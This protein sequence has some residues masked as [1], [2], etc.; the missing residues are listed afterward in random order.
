MT[1]F[2]ANDYQLKHYEIGLIS[3]AGMHWTHSDITALTVRE[4]KYWM[5]VAE[6]RLGLEDA[7][8]SAKTR[9]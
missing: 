7:A 9:G 3:A 4:R 8:Q 2:A 5:M 1:C 6:K